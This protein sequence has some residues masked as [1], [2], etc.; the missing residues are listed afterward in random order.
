MNNITG[1]ITL[2]DFEKAFD[3]IEWSLLGQC[4]THFNFGKTFITWIKV[5]YQN[6]KSCVGNNGYY[7]ESF[8]VSWS[9]RQGCPTSALLFIRVAEL[10]AISI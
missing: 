2:I 6:I 3:N 4:L 10:V 1:Y 7:T 5:L 9:V 8:D